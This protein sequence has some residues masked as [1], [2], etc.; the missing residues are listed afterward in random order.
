MKILAVLM[1]AAFAAASPG[2]R[3]GKSEASRPGKV[4]G[5][6]IET[7][8]IGSAIRG[9]GEAPADAAWIRLGSVPFG[10]ND[11]Y[12]KATLGLTEALDARGIVIYSRTELIHIKGGSCWPPY[13]VT[14]KIKLTEQAGER[15]RAYLQQMPLA[16]HRPSIERPEGYGA[17][18]VTCGSGAV[19]WWTVF[20]SK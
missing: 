16:D 20:Y 18:F 3:Q 6:D 4:G 2:C 19:D 11:L 14:F 9:T 5:C 7:I 12:K 13:T 8:K 17:F 1:I 10:G 15:F